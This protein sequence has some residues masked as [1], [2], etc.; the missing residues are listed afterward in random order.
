MICPKCNSI[1][2]KL[3]PEQSYSTSGEEYYKCTN[4]GTRIRISKSDDATSNDIISI[5]YPEIG[6]ATR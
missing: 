5:V 6:D 3:G 2:I 4:C 1:T